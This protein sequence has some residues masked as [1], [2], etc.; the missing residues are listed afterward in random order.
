MLGTPELRK[1][2]L[3]DMKYTMC[4]KWKIA[5]NRGR[6][7]FCFYTTGALTKAPKLSANLSISYN[8]EVRL[9]EQTALPFS[10]LSSRATTLVTTPR[11]LTE[12]RLGTVYPYNAYFQA[13]PVRP[14]FKIRPKIKMIKLL[15][16]LLA[17]ETAVNVF[18]NCNSLNSQ[19]WNKINSTRIFKSF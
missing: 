16:D 1:I 6:A 2:M 5:S 13:L 11:S 12:T 10:Q 18:N 14:N 8:S 17:L 9:E 15:W 19:Y 7:D 4:R 3:L